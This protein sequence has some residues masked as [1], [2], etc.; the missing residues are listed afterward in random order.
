ME[1]GDRIWVVDQMQPVAVVL[2]SR[3]SAQVAT[4]AWP[5]LPPVAQDSWPSGWQVRPASDGLWVQ[6]AGGPLALVTE[7]GLRSGHLSGGRTLGAV[8]AH[9]SWCLPEP[10]VQ[11][12]AATEDTPPRGRDGFHQLFLAHP[13]RT[14][15]TVLLDAPLHAACSQDG[16]LYLKVE[17]DRW[18]R[19]NLGTP[20]SW[21]LKPELSWLRLPA[22]ESPPDQLSL[23][24]HASAPPRDAESA[25]RDGGRR[26]G[27]RWLPP[28]DH[29][30]PHWG[31]W[32][33]DPSPNGVEWWAGWVGHGRNRHVT[34][35][36][37]EAGTTIQ[38]HQVDLGPGTAHAAIATAGWLWLALERPT[39]YVTYA[40]PPPT[41]LIRVRAADG[42]VETVLPADAV[43]V[44]A[45]C[46]P[47]P[48]EPVDTEDYTAFNRDRL[49]DLDHYWTH[50]DGHRAPL[51]DGLGDSRVDVVG[52]WPDTELHVT[53]AYAPRPGRRLRRIVPLFD[54]LGRQASPESAAIHLMETLD[55]NDIP[56]DAAPGADYL[57][58]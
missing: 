48:P 32:A 43:D 53:F 55:T 19:R 37:R 41:A 38:R 47:L 39:R 50:P 18:S 8:S 46:W 20:D 9:G 15:V 24:T 29:D 34:V 4:V 12:I 25:E 40:D 57:D 31:P 49:T 26:L 30:N 56:E 2:D 10:P 21:D 22:D 17:T 5:E 13:D 58:I 11:D 27:S 28:A 16:A 52:T 51:T 36:A 42:A 45:H 44:T 14:T 23:T 7:D 6:Q 33:T 3:T 35:L 54:E 1:V